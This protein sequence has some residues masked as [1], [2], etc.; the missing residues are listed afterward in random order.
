MTVIS[1]AIQPITRILFDQHVSLTDYIQE[2]FLFFIITLIMLLM[3]RFN[4]KLLISNL[5]FELELE[6]KVEERTNS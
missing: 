5:L 3:N 6:E 4:V 2:I 1:I